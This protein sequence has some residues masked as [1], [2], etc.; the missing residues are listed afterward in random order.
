VLESRIASGELGPGD[1]LPAERALQAEFEVA[2]SVIRQALASLSRD[3]L[4]QAAYPRGYVV[5][6]PRIPWISRLRL[7]HDE[8]PTVVMSEVGEAV[9]SEIVAEALGIPSGSPIAERHSTLRGATSGQ[10]WGLGLTSYP[11]PAADEAGR[12]ILLGQTEIDYDDLET[13]FGRRIIGYHERIRARQ[14][15][16]HEQARL[17][18]GPDVPVLEMARISRTTTI[19]I[20][21]FVF[22]GRADCFEAD[23]LIQP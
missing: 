18:S 9:A 11:L 16:H 8:P 20:S 12:S 1:R 14:P 15:T 23:Y 4:V 21:Y 5:L 3:G 6:G 10:T 22:V 2:R 17:D 13:A 19:P 7:L